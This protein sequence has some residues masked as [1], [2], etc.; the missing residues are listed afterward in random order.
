MKK[1]NFKSI[2][3]TALLM[4]SVCL[5]QSCEDFLDKAPDRRVE[6]VRL[7]QVLQLLTSAYPSGNYG[8]LCE[9][10]SDNVIDVNAPFYAPQTSSNYE[11]IL[12]HYHLNSYNRMDDEIYNF[13]PVRSYKGTDSP[14]YLWQAFYYSIATVNH[15]LECLDEIKEKEGYTNDD[16]PANFRA[17]YGEAY[18]I[19]AY[20]HFI[21]VNIFSQAY[22]NDE[23]SKA[24]IGIPYVTETENVVFG[25]YNRG[26]VTDTYKKIEE[27]L[28]KGLALIS[29][30]NFSEVRKYH[31]N[32]AAAHALASRF[33]LYKREYDKVIKHAD[34]VL[35]TDYTVLPSK[36]MSWVRFDDCTTSTDKAEVWQD[37]EEANNIML[38][39]TYSSQKRRAVGYRYS[40]A[41]KAQTDVQTHLGA[42]YRW[43]SIPCG[44]VGGNYVSKNSD[45]GVFS[46]RILER[47]EYTNK[48]AGTG[49]AHIVRREFTGCELLLERAEAK[50]LKQNPDI[51]GAIQDMIAYEDSR[52]AFS[53]DTYKYRTANKA[54]WPLTKED[55]DKWYSINEVNVLHSNVI[56]DWS[57]TQNVSSDFIVPENVYTYMN[58]LNDMRRFETAWSG[59][60]FFDLKRFGME[61]FHVYGREV[62]SGVVGDTLVMTANDKRR[63]IEIPQEALLAGLPSSFEP[64]L[65]AAELDEPIEQKDSVSRFA[66]AGKK[67]LLNK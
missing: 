25:T 51:D 65:D 61:Y 26:N 7:D 52:M 59:R 45:Y 44:S 48:V 32:V 37:P 42:N 11:A 57:F 13:E 33:Y 40:C 43:Y 24:D 16:L 19:R 22:K 23:A 27:D 34:A 20:C 14:Y 66:P 46:G 29:N 12:V 41:G 64:A 15:A 36:L 56:A 53:E 67:R 38:Y 50:L 17:A 4:S 49:Y 21:L 47:F 6:I 3:V 18:L 8:A 58:C 10:S 35:G 60:R 55:I 5:L 62:E 30:T 54:M 1:I 39:I 9:L 31:F 28:E 2:I 63:A